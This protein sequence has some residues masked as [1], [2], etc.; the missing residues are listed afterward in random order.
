MHY[1]ILTMYYVTLSQLLMY[2]RCYCKFICF[3][4]D[5]G[6]ESTANINRVIVMCI[7]HLIF[8]LRAYQT[9]GGMWELWEIN[10]VFFWCY[11]FVEKKEKNN[12]NAI[13]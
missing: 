11:H 13:N 10:D 7:R 1:Y 3:V 5:T 2:P 6:L 4:Y 8:L 9:N 12:K